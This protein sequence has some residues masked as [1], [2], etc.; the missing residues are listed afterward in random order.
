MSLFSDVISF[1]SSLHINPARVWVRWSFR[2]VDN[3]YVLIFNVKNK[4]LHGR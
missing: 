1:P 3:D 4:T 2:T